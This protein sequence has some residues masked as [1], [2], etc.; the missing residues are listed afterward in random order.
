MWRGKSRCFGPVLTVVMAI[1][2]VQG[3]RGRATDAGDAGDAVARREQNAGAGGGG[4]GSGGGGWVGG[5]WPGGGVSGGVSRR[6][7]RGNWWR[8]RGR[9]CFGGCMGRGRGGI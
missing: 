8:R 2:F 3:C 1:W 6:R 5:S 4:K 9:S 7:R